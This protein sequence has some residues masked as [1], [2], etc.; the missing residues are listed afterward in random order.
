MILK[1]WFQLSPY[2]PIYF[3]Y[4]FYDHHHNLIHK[5]GIHKRWSYVLVCPEPSN[6]V[7]IVLALLSITSPFSYHPDWMINYMVILFIHSYSNL[8]KYR[9]PGFKEH[10]ALKI[11]HWKYLAEMGYQILAQIQSN[12]YFNLIF[13]KVPLLSFISGR[14]QWIGMPVLVQEEGIL[15]CSLLEGHTSLGHTSS[16]QLILSHSFFELF[17][18]N[19][20]LLIKNQ[21]SWPLLHFS[22]TDHLLF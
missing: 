3:H 1:F 15:F 10:L 14:I 17:P 12:T 2:P 9:I 16:K 6:F 21:S 11:F 20:C 5:N 19:A 7:S 8:Q 13:G 18:F 22:E 4:H